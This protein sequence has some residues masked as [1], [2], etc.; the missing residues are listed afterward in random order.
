MNKSKKPVLKVVF[1]EDEYEKPKVLFGYV[2]DKGD[3]IE[4]MTTNGYLFTVNKKNIVF[5][6]EGGYND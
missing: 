2:T 6:K 3:F 1:K 5:T 4:V